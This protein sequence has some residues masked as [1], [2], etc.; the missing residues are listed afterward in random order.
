MPGGSK[1]GVQDGPKLCATLALRRGTRIETRT[2]LRIKHVIEHAGML[3]FARGAIFVRYN[4]SFEHM[5]DIR[6]LPSTMFSPSFFPGCL[7]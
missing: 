3:F 2:K 7:S 4:A 1:D 6:K 5:S